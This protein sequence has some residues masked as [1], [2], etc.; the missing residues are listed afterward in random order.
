MNQ[1]FSRGG[2]PENQLKI[3]KE[4]DIEDETVT[5]YLVARDGEGGTSWTTRTA[6]IN[7]QS[8]EGESE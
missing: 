2:K 8:G 7:A 4:E 6:L 1:L 3:P 5:L